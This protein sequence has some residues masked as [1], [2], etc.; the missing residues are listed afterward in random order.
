MPKPE[1]ICVDYETNVYE[2]D[3]TQGTWF[4]FK[5][6][7]FFLSLKKENFLYRWNLIPFFLTAQT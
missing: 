4:W 2:R 7:S 6:F 5:Y 1:Y 3:C